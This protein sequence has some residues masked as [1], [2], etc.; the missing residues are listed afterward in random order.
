MC[1][2]VLVDGTW[3]ATYHPNLALIDPK[4][5]AHR[6]ATCILKDE[7]RHIIKSFSVALLE[8]GVVSKALEEINN[9]VSNTECTVKNAVRMAESIEISADYTVNTNDSASYGVDINGTLIASV[10]IKIIVGFPSETK[11]TFRTNKTDAVIFTK[12]GR[13]AFPVSGNITK[14]LGLMVEK[15]YFKQW[16][17][18]EIPG[19]ILDGINQVYKIIREK[20]DSVVFQSFT[21]AK[22]SKVVHDITHANVKRKIEGTLGEV[23]EKAKSSGI[24]EEELNT[25]W[26]EALVRFVLEC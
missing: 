26:K 7:P 24:S 22:N 21:D 1:L 19:P 8:N 14:N 20:V 4:R 25:M 6:I 15:E 23:I 5:M 18:D 16:T 13:S 11:T 17:R 12:R 3:L 10:T 2:Y 9:F